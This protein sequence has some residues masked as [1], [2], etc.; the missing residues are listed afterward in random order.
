MSAAA[1]SKAG[2]ALLTLGRLPKG[3]DLARA[4]AQAGWRVLVAEPGKRHLCGSSRAVSASFQVAAPFN[5]PE[6]YL[7]DLIEIIERES[8]DL[9]LPVSEEILHV[10]ALHDRVGPGVRIASM[11]LDQL[12]S[13]HGKLSFVRQAEAFGLSAPITHRLSEANGQTLIQDYAAIIKREFSCAGAGLEMV[14]KGAALPTRDQ[15]DEWLVQQRIDGQELCSFTIA[16]RGRSIATVVYR[17]TVVSGTVAVCFKRIDPDPAVVDWV[18]RY[19]E[20]AGLSGFIGFDL[21]VNDQGEVF[22][23]ECNPRATSGVH[24]FKQADLASAIIDPMNCQ[25]LR[26]KAHRL[27][28]QFYP[29]LTE[30]QISFFKRDQFV[31]K[32]GQ[33]LRARDV[34]WQLSDPLPFLLLPW[35]AWAILS[36]TLFKGMSFGEAATWDIEW[37]APSERAS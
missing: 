1:G 30:T 8:V 2:T 27:F 17:G 3:L 21:M 19:I 6:A 9:V 20:G 24:F 34:S 13:V 25:Q 11:P 36:K 31:H 4:L 14:A 37:I 18:E 16:D 28:Q 12:L 10:A 23:L 33:L 7:S 29:T 5:E 22:G 26:F 15:P 35:T 32:L